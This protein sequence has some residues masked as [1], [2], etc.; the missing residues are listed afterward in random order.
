MVQRGYARTEALPRPAGVVSSF[1]L[2]SMGLGEWRIQDGAVITDYAKK[3]IEATV[4]E[5]LQEREVV[6]DLLR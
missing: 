3:K 5:L 2:R 4:Q 6:S 1:P